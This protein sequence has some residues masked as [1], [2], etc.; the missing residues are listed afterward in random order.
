MHC[1]WWS[2]SLLVSS[3]RPDPWCCAMYWLNNPIQYHYQSFE[4]VMIYLTTWVFKAATQRLITRNQRVVCIYVH[5]PYRDFFFVLAW[6]MFLRCSIP[7]GSA[8]FA[9]CG[10]TVWAWLGDSLKWR[11]DFSG[12]GDIRYTTAL[13]H[14]VLW[15]PL[16]W[17]G[18][19]P[20]V[21]QFRVDIALMLEFSQLFDGGRF[22]Y[23]ALG[24]AAS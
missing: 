19:P 23:T 16:T 8:C 18:F 4:S 5:P 2:F 21:N 12:L 14:A 9:V 20:I 17:W 3:S 13:V 24:R 11:L 7:C 6:P 1:L 22:L 10:R 15:Y